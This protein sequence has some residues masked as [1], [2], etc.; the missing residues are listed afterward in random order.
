[1]T[2]H[3]RAVRLAFAM[4]AIAMSIGAGAEPGSAGERRVPVDPNAP[5]WNAIVKVQTNIGSRCTGVLI[6]PTIVLTAAHCLY[7]PRTR[8]LLEAV[9]LHVLLGYERGA[10]RW[11]R[12]V[13]RYVVGRGFEGGKG[14]QT[15]DWA[16]F[17]L[18]E[19]IPDAVAPL[20]L[21]EADPA[22]GV[23]VSLAGYNQDRAQLLLA[24]LSC[25][26]IRTFVSADGGR[27]ITHDC[28]ATRGTSGAPLLV[29]QESGWAVLGINI[30]AGRETNFALVISG[31]AR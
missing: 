3:G 12:L 22:P 8:T 1:L 19:P 25:Q 11:H 6:A 10:Y 27:L 9:S 16:R 18:T 2:A 7:N 14:P 5:P 21:A 20:P 17:Q 23:A 29:R 4:L 24:D 28:A 13:A 31:I 15:A 30:A 26:V